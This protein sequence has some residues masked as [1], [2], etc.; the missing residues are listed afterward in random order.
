MQSH[1][2]WE[3]TQHVVF[4][5]EDDALINIRRPELGDEHLVTDFYIYNFGAD[6]E[7]FALLGFTLR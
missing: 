1:E 6:R 2:L 7:D 3:S 5:H 4:R